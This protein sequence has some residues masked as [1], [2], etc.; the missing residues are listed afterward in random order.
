MSTPPSAVTVDTVPSI[1]KGALTHTTHDPN[2]A[3]RTSKPTTLATAVAS[4]VPTLATRFRPTLSVTHH[5]VPATLQDAT[6]HTPPDLTV[7]LDH[8][9]HEATE[10]EVDTVSLR[11][12]SLSFGFGAA[13][14]PSGGISNGS[15]N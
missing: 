9:G 7:A 1:V 10:F 3:Y 12:P 8:E 13:A 15:L 4:L 2:V 6:T 14:A 5:A 11:A